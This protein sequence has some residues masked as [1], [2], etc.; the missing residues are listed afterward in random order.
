M[1]KGLDLFLNECKYVNETTTI[2]LHVYSVAKVSLREM[3]SLLY[4]A[5]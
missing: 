2:Y 1:N 5:I 4:N 3:V